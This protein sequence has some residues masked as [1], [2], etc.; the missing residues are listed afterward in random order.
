MRGLKPHCDPLIWRA[1]LS[2]SKMDRAVEL[3]ELAI[4]VLKARGSWESTKSGLSFF[5]CT[6]DQLKIS[7]REPLLPV[8]PHGLDIWDTSRGP[9]N[10]LSVEYNENDGSVAIVSCHLGTWEARLEKLACGGA[11]H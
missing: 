2:Q 10:V 1:E 6:E 7:Y 5:C 3:F 8:L 11:I 9:K 4:A